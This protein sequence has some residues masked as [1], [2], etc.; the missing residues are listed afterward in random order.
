MAAA[1]SE[2]KWRLVLQLLFVFEVCISVCAVVN[3]SESKI[4]EWVSRRQSSDFYHFI[5]SSKDNCGNNN[6]YLISENQCVKD[7]ELFRGSN[8]I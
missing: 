4:L 5:N 3:D 7:Q 1:E 2:R 8:I 6:T